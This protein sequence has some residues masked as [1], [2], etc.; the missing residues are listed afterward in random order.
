MAGIIDYLQWRGDL[1]FSQSPLNPVDNLIFS[2]LSYLKLTDILESG[3]GMSLNKIAR[4]YLKRSP[5][6]ELGLLLKGEYRRMLEL[7]S[8][9]KRYGGLVIRESPDIYDETIGV[10][11]AAT[12]IELDQRTVFIAF[13]GTDDTLLGWKEDFQMSF[14]DT[15]PAQQ[16]ALD[17]VNEVIPRYKYK[18]VYIGGHS[19][20]GN[21]AVYAAVHLNK[22]LKSR[23]VNV[24]NN[25]GPGFKKTLLET[26]DYQSFADRIITFVP[27]SSVVG[28]LLEHEEAYKVVRSNQHGVLQHDG[29][30]WEIAGPDFVYL[31]EV[32]DDC[33]TV[34]RTFK[35][36]LNTLSEQQRRDYTNAFFEIISVNENRTLTELKKDGFK[37]LFSISKNYLAL[38]KETKK[39]VAETVT[40][41]FE[42]GF[43]NFLEI[44]N[45]DQWRENLVAL[46]KPKKR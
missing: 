18:K 27:Q 36:I 19:K 1:D 39:V 45:V 23:I 25:D 26:P 2:E 35:D 12:L 5:G 28:M 9:S 4:E 44:K 29:F 13:R 41:F 3:H 21:L 14:M 16:A 10:Q 17:Y 33:L 38:D 22:N 6:K 11:F 31:S 40:M 42:R 37:T 7:M 34:D 32:T 30:S 24:F 20:G 43:L 46:T 15:V 8:E